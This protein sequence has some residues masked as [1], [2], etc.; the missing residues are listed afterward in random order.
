MT[1]A[2]IHI[3]RIWSHV[4]E[5]DAVHLLLRSAGSEERH[6]KLKRTNNPALYD[7]ITEHGAV[8]LDPAADVDPE[9]AGL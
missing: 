1:D 9:T 8:A 6:I 2:P 4:G 7:F 5:V 3:R